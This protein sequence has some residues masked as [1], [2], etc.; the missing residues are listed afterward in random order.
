MRPLAPTGCR[1]AAQ[2]EPVTLLTEDG[3][4]SDLP[5]MHEGRGCCV[6]QCAHHAQIYRVARGKDKCS[7]VT[8]HSQR[9]GARGGVPLCAYHLEPGTQVNRDEEPACPAAPALPAPSKPSLLAK[10][11]NRLHGRSESPGRSLETART[12]TQG[13]P[14]LPDAAPKGD[15]SAVDADKL[16]QEI[17]QPLQLLAWKPRRRVR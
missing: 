7:V 5:R 11:G 4:M 6:K 17:P 12:Q 2:L 16:D 15:R 8:C 1:D 14:S 9:A 10:V 13:P 3:E